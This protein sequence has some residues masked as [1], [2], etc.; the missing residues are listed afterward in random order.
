MYPTSLLY[1]PPII[2]TQSMFFQ[3]LLGKAEAL[4]IFFFFL[5]GRGRQVASLLNYFLGSF[6][7]IKFSLFSLQKWGNENTHPHTNLYTNVLNSTHNTQG[8]ETTQIS[9]N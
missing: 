9:N 4:M 6:S 8:G 5:K 1:D 2:N 7:Q 3:I